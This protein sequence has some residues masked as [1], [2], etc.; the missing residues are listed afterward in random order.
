MT[1]D[2]PETVLDLIRDAARGAGLTMHREVSVMIDVGAHMLF[3]EVSECFALSGFSFVLFLEQ[4]G[5]MNFGDFQALYSVYRLRGL[6]TDSTNLAC[7]E[8]SKLV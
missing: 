4:G 3:D 5:K 8:L 7:L 2:K 1:A 6:V